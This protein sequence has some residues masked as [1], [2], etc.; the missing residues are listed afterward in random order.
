MC[1]PLGPEKD[2]NENGR[3]KE[4]VPCNE[5]GRWF[6]QRSFSSFKEIIGVAEPGDGFRAQRIRIG[7][8]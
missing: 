2:R 5:F 7:I 1:L 3:R 4:D 6:R 8:G